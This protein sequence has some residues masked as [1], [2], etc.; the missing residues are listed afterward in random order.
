MEKIL[1]ILKIRFK[2]NPHRHRNIDWEDVEERLIE[3]S[4]WPVLLK[5]EES[6]GE[7]DVIGIDEITGEFIY[8]DCAKESPKERRSTTYDREGEEKRK[9]KNIFPEGNALDMAEEIGIEILDEDLYRSLQT[10]EKVDLKS[11]SWLKTPE[12]IRDLGGA[13]FGDNRFD[14]VFIY[15]NGAESFYSSRGFRGYIKV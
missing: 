13:I 8:C 3:K 14:H 7:P 1:E 2:E 4:L 15:H 11:S 6:G 9:K 10:V 5:M 12:K